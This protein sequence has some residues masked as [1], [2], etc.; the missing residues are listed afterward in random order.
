MRLFATKLF[1]KPD[2]FEQRLQREPVRQIPPDWRREIL[3]AARAAQAPVHASRMTH[4][5]WLSTVHHQLSALL[6]PQ[7]KAWAG[8]AAVWVVIFAVNFSM[9]DAAPMMAGKTAPPS[10]EVMVEL[11]KQQRMFAELVGSYEPVDAD[12]RNVFS[13]KP[14]SGRVEILMT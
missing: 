12:R 6:W 10:P 4:H 8:L 13:P 7:P 1:M 11:K 3:T 5:S 2:D 9:R 14:R